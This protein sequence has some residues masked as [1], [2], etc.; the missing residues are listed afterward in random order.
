ML[1]ILSKLSDEIFHSDDRGNPAPSFATTLC[2]IIRGN[3]N[4]VLYK[5]DWWLIIKDVDHINKI[6]H[7]FYFSGNIW[8]SIPSWGA[9][10]AFFKKNQKERRLENFDLRDTTFKKFR[11]LIIVHVNLCLSMYNGNKCIKPMKKR[12]H[13]T[14]DKTINGFR[15]E[16][17][18]I[19]KIFKDI[20]KIVEKYSD[21]NNKIKWK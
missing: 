8:W 7:L 2:T 16:K 11:V 12:N 20:L 18:R 1:F 9:S 19:A 21:Q 17:I 14:Y 15:N 3:K 5:S 6:N 4:L 13:P 10:M